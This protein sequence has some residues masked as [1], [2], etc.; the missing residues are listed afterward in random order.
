MVLGKAHGMASAGSSSLT[1]FGSENTRFYVRDIQA[2]ETKE[3]SPCEQETCRTAIMSARLQQRQQTRH[4]TSPR[5]MG[6]R[7]TTP[8]RCRTLPEA[9]HRVLAKLSTVPPSL[10]V[11]LSAVFLPTLRTGAPSGFC[12]GAG[13]P[14]SLSRLLSV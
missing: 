6:T 14:R 1:D 2:I 8:E 4:P 13:M 11:L 3:V 12:P 10:P 5:T 7:P 9:R